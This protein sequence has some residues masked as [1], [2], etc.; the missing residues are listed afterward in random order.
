MRLKRYFRKFRNR[1]LK[2]VLR[3]IS[4]QMLIILVLIVT[5]PL[6]VLG[7]LLIKTSREAIRGSVLQGHQELATRAASEV[8][9]FIRQPRELLAATA[10]ILGTIPTNAWSQET[11]LVELALNNPIFNRISLINKNGMEIAASELGSQLKDRADEWSFISALA[12]DFYISD[13]YIRDNHTPYIKLAAPVI[14]LG[15]V[16]GVLFA[17]ANLR[18]MWDIVDGI[19]LDKTGIAYV[20][21]DKGVLI[22]HPDKKRVLANQDM[23]SDKI[24]QTVL[25]GRTGSAEYSGDNALRQIASFAPIPGL[26]WGVVVTQSTDEAFAYSWAM[27]TQSWALIISSELVAIIISI[28][29]ARAL[30]K[31]IRALAEASKQ[32]AQGRLDKNIPSKRKDELGELVRSFNNMI[33]KLNHAKTVERLSVVG[34]AA[35]AIV[36]ELKNSL[37]M[38]YTYVG[39]FPKKHKDKKF[40]EKF[41]RTV[42]QEL[43]RWKAMLQDLSDFSRGEKIDFAFD[44]IDLSELIKDIHYLIEERALQGNIKLTINIEKELPRIQGNSQKLKQVFINLATNAIEAMPGGG[45]LD[46]SV[47]I[48]N[49]EAKQEFQYVEIKVRDSGKGISRQHLD[50]LF[51]PFHTTKSN[52]MGLG[53]AISRN[54]IQQHGGDIEVENGSDQGTCFNVRLPLKRGL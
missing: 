37:V 8:G 32:V 45:S 4:A 33:K 6:S 23:L 17:E 19:K 27:K 50:K 48:P 42:P 11:V 28:M 29:I 26:G 51:L 43:E 41:S 1:L 22:A 30:V 16:A 38:V 12:G 14:K 54:I 21:S 9:L 40:L 34:K 5:I 18:G 20:V 15:E 25:S 44:E 10:S 3:R 47:T 31:P 52:G 46:L 39:M 35:T 53:L 24:I 7:I 2:L 36:H 13:V 49:G